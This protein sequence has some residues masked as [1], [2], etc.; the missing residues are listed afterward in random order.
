MEET[1]DVNQTEPSAVEQIANAGVDSAPPAESDEKL[2]WGKDP[3]F[4]KWRTDEKSLRETLAKNEQDYKGLQGYVYQNR[5]A[6]D[7]WNAL[8]QDEQKFREV[9]AVLTGQARP[10][11]KDPYSE[12]DP[13]IAE[14]LRRLDKLEQNYNSFTTQNQTERQEMALNQN[15]QSLEQNFYGMCEKSRVTREADQSVLASLCAVNLQ[16]L[17]PGQDIR[18]ASQEL[19]NE[20]FRKAMPLLED[21]KK[22]ERSSLTIPVVPPSGSRTGV[23]AR[24]ESWENPQERI[25]QMARELGG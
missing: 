12:Y 9:Q 18:Y 1:Q 22:S 16:S 17:M 14:K 25:S 23:P 20:A 3:R 21:I 24:Q 4:Q 13:L 15:F 5:Q 11:Q 8:S 7:W 10:E 19:L 2:P 6:I